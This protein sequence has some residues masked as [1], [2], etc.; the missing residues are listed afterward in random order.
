MPREDTGQREWSLTE[1]KKDDCSAAH[2]YSNDVKGNEAQDINTKS[3]G[4]Q[5][6][7]IILISF[8]QNSTQKNVS[9]PLSL[10]GHD[11]ALHGFYFLFYFLFPYF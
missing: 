3:A 5:T 4:S 10:G 9:I 11:R 2:L 1:W 6:V 8:L 7:H